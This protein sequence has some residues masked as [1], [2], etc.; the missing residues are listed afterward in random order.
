MLVTTPHSFVLCVCVS[1]CDAGLENFQAVKGGATE[2]SIVTKVLRVLL[3]L[4]KFSNSFLCT[5][6]CFAVTYSMNW[7]SWHCRHTIW[8]FTS[9]I[10]NSML[11]RCP[12]QS[13]YA[14]VVRPKREVKF[15]SLIIFSCCGKCCWTFLLSLRPHPDNWLAV[16]CFVV[17]FTTCVHICSPG[18]QYWSSNP[19][20][21]SIEI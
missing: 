15:E 13:M 7:L 19:R 2:Y 4:L 18:R 17:I 14:F 8:L 11:T 10:G 16:F 5:C 6:A 1:W 9:T 12:V 21:H 3:Y 20:R